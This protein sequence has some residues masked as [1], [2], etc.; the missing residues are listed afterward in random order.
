[1]VGSF[2]ET[3]LKIECNDASSFSGTE[4]E[5]EWRKGELSKVTVCENKKAQETLLL[6]QACRTQLAYPRDRA[7]KTAITIL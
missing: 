2:R 4:H 3:V 6:G 5:T 1:M 7:E